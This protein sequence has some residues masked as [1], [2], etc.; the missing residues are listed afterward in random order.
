MYDQENLQASM[1]SY[2]RFGT[3]RAE[4]PPQRMHLLFR[5]NRQAA[6]MRV[7]FVEKRTHVAKNAVDECTPRAQR[8][9]LPNA[10]FKAYV[11]EHRHLG[12]L[13]A[14]HGKSEKQDDVSG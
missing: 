3:T 10:L 11:A 1:F 2:I 6:G 8:M 4:V 7:A 12:F 9:V 14:A 5:R 13:L